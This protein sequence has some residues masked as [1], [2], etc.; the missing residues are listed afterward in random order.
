MGETTSFARLHNIFAHAGTDNNTAL[1]H[2]VKGNEPEIVA[3]LLNAGAD[4]NTV[5]PLHDGGAN[6]GPSAENSLLS[7]AANRGMEAVVELLLA[8]GADVNDDQVMRENSKRWI[9]NR[10]IY[11]HI[12]PLVAAA[13]A[14][15]D[16]SNIV[17]MLLDK[18]AKVDVVNYT[19]DTALSKAV[20]VGLRYHETGIRMP[21]IRI[22]AE[23]GANPNLP[24]LLVSAIRYGDLEMVKF[25]VEH[26]ADINAKTMDAN[27]E[28]QG[29]RYQ[30]SRREMTPLIAAIE[31]TYVHK[32]PLIESLKYLLEQGADVNAPDGEGDTPLILAIYKEDQELCKLLLS[33]RADPNQRQHT[34][35]GA[36]PLAIAARIRNSDIVRLLLAQGAIPDERDFDNSTF[37]L[38]ERKMDGE[39]P[40]TLLMDT[41]PEELRKKIRNALAPVPA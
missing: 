35:H 21:T 5:V 14:P 23:A 15:R 38:S 11:C 39:D 16:N 13:W 34:S 29:E 28:L 6:T 12:P 17:R 25:L 32:T 2:A 31:G 40:A 27:P 19:G 26:K 22:L 24:P 30:E 8:H 10:E 18:G 3:D 41:T 37:R 9:G 7:H 1:I 33:H 36:S 4:P 20:L